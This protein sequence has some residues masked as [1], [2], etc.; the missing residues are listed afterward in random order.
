MNTRVVS[1]LGGLVLAAAVGTGVWWFAP[2]PIAP[3]EDAAPLG[4]MAL[5]LPPVPPRVASGQEYEQCLDLLENDPAGAAAFAEGW[6]AGQ[7]GAAHCLALSRIALG[8]PAEGAAAL[9][10]MAGRSTAPT[11]VRAMLW[12]QAGQAWVMADEGE[13]AYAAMTRAVGLLGDDVELLIERAGVAS[14][15]ERYEDALADLDQVLAREP[16][17]VDAMTLRA[18]A[19]RRLERM[20]AAE[21]E[22]ARALALDPDFPE[23]LLE[24][25]I[26]RQ[27]KG[28]VEGAR[29]DW[30]RAI[31]ID[32]DSPT[33]DLAEQN[34]ALLDAGPSSRP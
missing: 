34:L 28:D 19:L 2:E 8:Q 23:G 26:L 30:E 11:A 24:R 32:P 9:E 12:G 18:A 29:A 33:A 27:R 22:V 7:E 4:G 10:A 25:G 17:R 3:S 13:R 5:P 20:A 1:F 15:L 31:E 14:G 6:A 16:G 21:A